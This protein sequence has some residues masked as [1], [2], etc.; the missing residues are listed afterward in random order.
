MKKAKNSNIECTDLKKG[1]FEAIA[2]AVVLVAVVS[3]V[4]FR[5]GVCELL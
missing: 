5:G 1:L 4:K 2:L 3:V